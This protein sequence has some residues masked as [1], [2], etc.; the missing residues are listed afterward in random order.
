[1]WV[2]TFDLDPS[3]QLTSI[4]ELQ[5]IPAFLFRSRRDGGAPRTT[6]CAA[7]TALTGSMMQGQGVLWYFSKNWGWTDFDVAFKIKSVCKNA[8][9]A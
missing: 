6:A 5:V 2:L 7:T 4:S 3:P 9:V 8:D 1:V